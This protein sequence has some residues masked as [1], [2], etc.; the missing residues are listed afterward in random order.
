MPSYTSK[1]NL[2]K[3]NTSTDGALLFNINQAL[4]NNW[5]NLEN[6]VAITIYNSQTTYKLN[7]CVL[8]IGDTVKLFKSLVNNNLN[9]ELT[10]T[11]YWQEISLGGSSSGG[12]E[13][14]DIGTA[15]YV[16]ET[17]GKRRYLNGTILPINDNTLPFLNWLKAIVATTPTL[18]TTEQAWQNEVNSSVFKQ[19][20]KFVINESVG[21]IRLP[22]V[23]NLQGLKELGQAGVT[24]TQSL[25]NITGSF[26]TELR[27]ATTTDLT[28]GAFYNTG[29]TI[30]GGSGE[31]TDWKTGF[32]ASRVSSTYQNNAP[33]QQE[34]IQYPYFI[35]IAT[36]SST[37][38]ANVLNQLEFNNPATLFDCKYSDHELFNVSWLRSYGQYN[39]K[40]VYVKAY[41]ALSVENNESIAPGTEVTLPSGTSY[42]KQGLSV[43]LST[44][45]YTDYDYVLNTTNESFRLPVKTLAL[46]NTRYLIESGE[47]S[48][49]SYRV[50]SDGYC[51]QWGSSF[52]DAAYNRTISLSKTYADTDYVINVSNSCA[53]ANNIYAANIKSNATNS[54]EVF[55][56]GATYNFYWKTCGFLAEDQYSTEVYLYYYIGEVIQNAN[57]INVGRISEQIVDLQSVPHIIEKV[58]YGTDGYRVWSDGYCEQWGHTTGSNNALFT[59]S[60]IK[61][62]KD[63]NYIIMALGCKNGSVVTPDR[64]VYYANKATN[65]F[66]LYRD[67][68]LSD[69]IDW[70]ATG[71]LAS[72]EY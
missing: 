5:D 47:E 14:G 40:S 59:I 29:V 51:E 45:T 61:A 22:K 48:G 69:G 17:E 62:F 65:S 63:I 23:V 18:S 41:E 58:T 44:G 7:D 15:L 12:L 31:G 56:N 35:Q 52:T 25:P 38:E 16:N 33:V 66:Q 8:Q 28:T 54:F 43:K 2:Y 3:Y 30:A 19:C 13:I 9:H 1:F 71:Y 26:P 11:D 55:N 34:A 68:V 32:D 4:N 10:N 36:D 60:L 39:L 42:I 21:T 6:R 72:G 24:I 70:K 27:T 20:G 50:Y 37:T 46:T 53:S 49:V 57:L 67:D 64:D